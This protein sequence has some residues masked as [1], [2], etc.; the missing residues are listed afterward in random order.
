VTAVSRNT[1]LL[2]VFMVGLDGRVWTAAWSPAA[3]VWKGWWPVGDLYLAKLAPVTG[4]ARSD[5]KLDVF[6]HG[7]DRAIYTAAWQ[8]GDKSWR[9]WWRLR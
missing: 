1:D 3:K 4:L 8:T 7:S 2:D 5:G 9:G 6:V